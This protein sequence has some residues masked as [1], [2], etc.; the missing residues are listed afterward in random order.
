M[1]SFS[2]N[3]ENTRTVVPALQAQSEGGEE[4][5]CV[6]GFLDCGSCVLSASRVMTTILAGR[7][8]PHCFSY[9]DGQ[10]RSQG[11][12]EAQRRAGPAA[13]QRT[14][15]T[16]PFPCPR[17]ALACA[18]RGREAGRERGLR[19]LVLP[20]LVPRT[21]PLSA[22]S[23]WGGLTARPWGGGLAVPSLCTEE[24]LCDRLNQ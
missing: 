22:P 6:A 4:P 24:G 21:H 7:Q 15:W 12:P 1:K 19:L 23:L 18:R 20:G 3:L 13:S 16:T 8:V 9:S 11:L 14:G 5:R 2:G 17:L 10:P